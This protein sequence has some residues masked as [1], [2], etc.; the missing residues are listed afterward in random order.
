MQVD[1]G[2]AKG[3]LLRNWNW[4]KQKSRI[5]ANPACVIKLLKLAQ[6]DLSKNFPAIQSGLEFAILGTSAIN[7]ASAIPAMPFFKNRAQQQIDSSFIPRP[8]ATIVFV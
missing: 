6:V 4:K 3:R 2:L 8:S 1:A 7:A 5:A